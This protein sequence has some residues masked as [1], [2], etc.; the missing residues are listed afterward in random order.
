MPTIHFKPDY[1][2]EKLLQ[3][4]AKIT[5]YDA[6]FKLLVIKHAAKTN[7]CASAWESYIKEECV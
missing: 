2:S 6:N 1:C 4:V 3:Y 7:N 5:G